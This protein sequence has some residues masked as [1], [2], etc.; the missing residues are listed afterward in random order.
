M[1]I[2][3]ATGVRP[4]VEADVEAAYA[5]STA[6]GW[7]QTVDD[8]GRLLELEPEG[9]F[10]IDDNG[11]AATTTVICHGS[12]LA[13]VGMVLTRVDCQRR[14]YARRL[15]QAALE[16]TDRRGIRCVKLDATD[17]GRPLYAS[18][19]F[20]DEQPIERWRREARPAEGAMPP[21]V[22]DDALDLEAF[23][24]D[25]SAFLR[26]VALGAARPGRIAYYL[27]PYV[28]RS[29]EEAR[30]TIRAIVAGDEGP[31]FWDLLPGHPHASRIA[32]EL[33]FERVRRLVRMV[34]G[35]QIQRVDSLVYAIGG[36]E[37]G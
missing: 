36:F 29:A 9:C 17:Q 28:S 16:L 30:A 24:A 8:W 11:L 25:R 26:T 22:R 19:G 1:E 7:N 15:V 13:W 4:L 31:W 21:V 27:G 20:V 2:G 10:G 32:A 35:P 37:A 14:G 3:S 5:L 12:A 23:G 33:G 18:L 6:A 34:R